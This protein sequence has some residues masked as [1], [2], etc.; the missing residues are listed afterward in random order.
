MSE[1]AVFPIIIKKNDSTEMPYLAI[2]P[3]LD[4]MTEGKS[5]AD[6]IDMA[7]DYIGTYSLDDELPKSNT[8]IPDTNDDEI[9]TLVSV[10]I[11]DYKKKHD[12]KVVKKTITIPNYLNELGK[13]E[14][15]N[16]SEVMTMALK[17]KLKV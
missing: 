13:E 3:D 8:N 16:F 6:V 17:D 10:N 11:S 9:G 7:Q 5:I 4:G 14:G 1:N 2:I 12:T 15:I